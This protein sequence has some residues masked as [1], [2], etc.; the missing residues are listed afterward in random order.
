M[1]VKAVGGSTI[2]QSIVQRFHASSPSCHL[3]GVHNHR[4]LHPKSSRE[5]TWKGLERRG[6]PELRGL[7]NPRDQNVYVLHSCAGGLRSPVEVRT[8][9]Y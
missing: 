5:R 6:R 8:R 9:N 7:R 2:D 4:L 3:E 1:E